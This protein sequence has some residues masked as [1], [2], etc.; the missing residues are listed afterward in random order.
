[1]ANV[2]HS[3]ATNAELAKAAA[4]ISELIEWADADEQHARENDAPETARDDHR[5]GTA[6]RKALALVKECTR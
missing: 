3:E 5:R 1:M 4:S 2:H 6:L